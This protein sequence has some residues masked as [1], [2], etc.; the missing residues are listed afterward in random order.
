[1][2]VKIG[3]IGCGT[4]SRYHL[5][6]IQELDSIEVVA[7]YNRGKANRLEFGRDA[8][9]SSD[10]LYS[11]V[12]NLI[13]HPGL[14]AVIN[15][16]PNSMHSGVS[17]EALEHG[18]HVLC[19]K[20]M[21]TSLKE[22]QEMI[23]AAKRNDKKLFIGLT[24]R[25]KGE[26]IAAKGII[27]DGTLGDIYY[28]NSAWM[29]RNGIPGWG[30]QFTRKD[31]AGAGPIYDIGVHALDTT[32]WLMDDFEAEQVL[33]SSYTKHGPYRRGLEDWGT[34]DWNGYYD[35]EDLSSA[36]IKM[37]SGTTINFEVSWAAHI[38]Y[39]RITAKLV[40]EK[41]GFDIESMMLYTTKDEKEID[42][43]IPHENTDAYLLEMQ[44]FV[45]CIKND[46]EP[47]TTPQQMLELQAMLDM[48]LLSSSE[49]RVIKRNE[50]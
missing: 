41:A 29:R 38:P 2:V 47:I 43:L 11:D 32:C 44:H 7:A 18:L 36:I 24:R 1:M 50:I 8:G 13:K 42:T 10:D 37:K 28:A 19:E 9:L 17:V 4:I 45:E 6:K 35:V 31:M 40:G 15:C 30:S 5:R 21:A 12:S 3:M 49:N 27:E 20:P 48:I 39:E 16:L 34:P 46:K 25:F 14:D 23:D 26:V 22:A 33:A